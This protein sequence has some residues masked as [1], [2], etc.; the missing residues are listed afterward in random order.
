VL[1]FFAV[2]C[3]QPKPFESQDLHFCFSDFIMRA[4]WKKVSFKFVFNVVIVVNKFLIC[5]QQSL[6]FLFF[7]QKNTLF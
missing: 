3:A 6:F 2:D 4:K 5:Q 7:A 1:C